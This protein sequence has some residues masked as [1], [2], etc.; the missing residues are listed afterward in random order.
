MTREE[1]IEEM[2]KRLGY[3]TWDLD[4]AREA[5]DLSHRTYWAGLDDSRLRIEYSMIMRGLYDDV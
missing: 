2:I 4:K 5:L 1:M 3:M